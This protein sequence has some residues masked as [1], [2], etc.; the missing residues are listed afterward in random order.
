M[1]TELIFS[2]SRD[3]LYDSREVARSS[4]ELQVKLCQRREYKR[5]QNK[6]PFRKDVIMS[7]SFFVTQFPFPQCCSSTSKRMS[8]SPQSTQV[9]KS[10]GMPFL[11]CSMYGNGVGA[12]EKQNRMFPPLTPVVR[13]QMKVPHQWSLAG[14]NGLGKRKRNGPTPGGGSSGPAPVPPRPRPSASA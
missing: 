5:I 8:H 6:Y 10:D 7:S 4:W 1:K 14:E 11:S 9:P 12:L 13:L 3:I 2:P